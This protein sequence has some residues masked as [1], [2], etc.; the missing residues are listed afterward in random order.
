MA[1]VVD[2][3]GSNRATF[4]RA[5]FFRVDDAG[6]LT[7]YIDPGGLDV[8]KLVVISAGNWKTAEVLEHDDDV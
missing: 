2:K 6:N 4:P 3:N 1:V 7:L 8:S 5:N